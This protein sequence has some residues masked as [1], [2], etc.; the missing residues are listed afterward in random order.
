MPLAKYFFK[1]EVLILTLYV[2]SE[3]DSIPSTTMKEQRL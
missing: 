3:V 1:S 2:L